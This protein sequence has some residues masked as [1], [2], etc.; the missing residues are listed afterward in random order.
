MSTDILATIGNIRDE[1]ER[2]QKRLRLALDEKDPELRQIHL[3]NARACL[4][5]VAAQTSAVLDALG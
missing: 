2:A 1:A 5:V 4:R 3:A